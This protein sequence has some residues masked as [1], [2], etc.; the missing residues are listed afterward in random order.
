MIAALLLL[1]GSLNS[2]PPPTEKPA[3]PRPSLVAQVG[4]AGFINATALSAD[5]TLV[6]TG[7]ADKTAKLW[8]MATGR[9]L[10]TFQGHT[11]SVTSVAFTSDGRWLVS[12][13]EDKTIRVWEVATGVQVRLLVGHFGSVTAVAVGRGETIHNGIG[14]LPT[15]KLCL[16]SASADKTIRLWDVVAGR[17]IGMLEG[18]A[19]AVTS[20]AFSSDGYRL[21]TGS[22]DRTARLWE[23]ASGKELTVLRG[24]EGSVDAVAISKDG[25]WLVTGSADKTVPPVG[26]VD[27]ARGAASLPGTTSA[28]AAWH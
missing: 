7:G 1:A 20:L 23:V 18:H 22:E 10:R 5:G 21:V 11:G 2:S 12:G 9:E 4:H 15:Q 25:K 13:S 8:E 14:R 27:G 17:V 24:H 16:A 28:S 26:P 19:G 3:G 6:V